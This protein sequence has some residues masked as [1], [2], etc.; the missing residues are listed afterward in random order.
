MSALLLL[1]DDGDLKNNSSCERSKH[2]NCTLGEP[3][4]R[5]NDSI[6]QHAV[7]VNGASEGLQFFHRSLLAKKNPFEESST[8]SKAFCSRAGQKFSKS[9]VC[10]GVSC[11]LPLVKDEHTPMKRMKSKTRNK[12]TAVPINEHAVVMVGR[13]S[14]RCTFNT[15]CKNIDDSKAPVVALNTKKVGSPDGSETRYCSMKTKEVQPYRSTRTP[16]TTVRALRSSRL[17]RE[18]ECLSNG[19]YRD[20]AVDSETS[21]RSTKVP[22]RLRISKQGLVCEPQE[23]SKLTTF[24]AVTSTDDKT[25][26]P[27]THISQSSN[28]LPP[29]STCRMKCKDKEGE[30]LSVVMGG[31][32]SEHCSR[33]SN[34]NWSRQQEQ[35]QDS[36]WQTDSGNHKG[37]MAKREKKRSSLLLQLA[38][39]EGYVA[40]KQ[41]ERTKRDSLLVDSSMLGREERALQVSIRFVL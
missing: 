2:V 1:G 21:K 22:I 37:A 11:T 38:N 18:M 32:T 8:D 14:E 39:S 34:D 30:I 9:R 13:Q 23:S 24:D 6:A 4:A 29:P 40:D 31:L 3:V 12:E 7:Q 28:I 20:A 15:P 25:D 27:Q 26:S 33:V 41:G 35:A 16:Q 19:S 17:K 5:T 36:Q 10:N